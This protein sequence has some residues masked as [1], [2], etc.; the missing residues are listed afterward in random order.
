MFLPA[1]IIQLFDN[2]APA[3]TKPTYRKA[4]LLVVGAILARGRRTVTSALR[5]MG[6]EQESDWSKYHHVLNRAQWSGLRVSEILLKLLVKTFISGRAPI[7]I[8]VDETLER[9]WGPQIRKRGHWRDSLASGRNMNVSASGLRWLVFALVIRLPWSPYYW[10]LPF[11]SIL[12]TTPKVSEKLGKRHKKVSQRTAQVICWLRRTLPGRP[13]HLVGDG[14]YSVIRLGLRAQK[15]GV[16]LIAPLRL[17]ARL[18]DLP[19]SPLTASGKKRRGRPPGVGQRLPNLSQIALSSSTVW[20]RSKIAWYGGKTEVVDWATGTALWYSSG[21]PPLAIRWVLVRDPAGERPLRAY[22]ATDQHQSAPAIIA[23]FVKRWSLEVTFEES[24]AVL[25][26]ETQRQW[27][28]KAIERT[29]PAL[30]GLYSL[31]VLM[32][33]A[34]FGDDELPLPQA[35]WYQKDH[36]TFHDMLFVVRHRL[37]LHSFFRTSVISPDL[38]LFPPG[39]GDSASNI[40]TNAWK[41][42]ISAACY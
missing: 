30:L 37:W 20:H 10:S 15:C 12:L 39:S 41:R 9:R 14:A 5:V 28:D 23:D 35:A 1:E 17:D 26:V 21:I 19:P 6:R 25:G 7:T 27:S 40:E 32:A 24:R 29:T 8:T 16:V 11:L 2:F 34:L 38:Y 42:L 22:F 33:H 31:V 13:I 3:F 4:I 18:F 36:A